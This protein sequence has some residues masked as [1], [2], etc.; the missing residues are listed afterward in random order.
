[1]APYSPVTRWK[2]DSFNDGA[3]FLLCQR[4]LAQ[5]L[6]QGLGMQCQEEP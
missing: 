1:M 6:E 5:R 2:R 3:K 4:D